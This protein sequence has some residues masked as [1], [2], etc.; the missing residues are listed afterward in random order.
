MITS[1]TNIVGI[2]D[3][4]QDVVQCDNCGVEDYICEMVQFIDK[5]TNEILFLCES[6]YFNPKV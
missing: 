2:N 5:D 1:N 4:D 6:C 3:V